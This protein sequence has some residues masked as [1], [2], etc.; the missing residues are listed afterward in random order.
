MGEYCS[1][2]VWQLKAGASPADL[3]MLAASGLAEM[4]RWIP[5]IKQLSL[6]RSEQEGQQPCYLL[7]TTFANKDAYQAWR[8]I[9]QEGPDYWERYASVLMH[10]E[11][12]ARLVEE[13]SGDLTDLS[14]LQDSRE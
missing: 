12:I 11:E 6:V 13:Y 14:P 1:V 8:R 5:G 3:E 4:H 9:E 7:L 10:W 2:R